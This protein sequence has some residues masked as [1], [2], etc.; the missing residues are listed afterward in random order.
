MAHSGGTTIP[1]PKYQNLDLERPWPILQVLLLSHL[2]TL[3]HSIAISPN[4]IT[5]NISIVLQEKRKCQDHPFQ[6]K[7][8]HTQP[9]SQLQYH[10]TI[11]FPHIGLQLAEEISGSRED[12]HG[13]RPLEYR[14]EHCCHHVSC[15]PPASPR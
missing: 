15:M 3:P 4:I 1:W 2:G 11:L 8:Q 7:Y 12:Q 9:T 5:F 13:N 10:S 14:C 6:A